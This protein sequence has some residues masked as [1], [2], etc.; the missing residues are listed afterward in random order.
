M[1]HRLD[2]VVALVALVADLVEADE[3]EVEHALLEVGDA[4]V[5]VGA[6]VVGDDGGGELGGG[7]VLERLEA[8]VDGPFALLE[9]R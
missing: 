3:L 5:E 7:E 8:A 2:A 9:G 4:R 6:L 1:F